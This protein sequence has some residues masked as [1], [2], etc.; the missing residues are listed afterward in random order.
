MIKPI[1]TVEQIPNGD[2]GIDAIVAKM[3]GLILKDRNEASVL[4]VA[5]KLKRPSD[6]KTIEATFNYVWKNY[7]YV[8]DPVDTEHLTAPRHIIG[9][10]TP[11]MD[12]DEMVILLNALL[13]A[14]KIPSRI[15]TIA[16][17]KKDFSHVISSAKF[18]NTWILLDPTKK[19]AGFGGTVKPISNKFWRMKKYG[20]PMGT[21]TT[22]DDC[23]GCRKNKKGL[24][25]EININIG[26]TNSKN[27]AGIPGKPQIVQLP[28]QTKTLIK[29][30]PVIYK[31]YVPMPT[32]SN[33][34][35][36]LVT[37]REYY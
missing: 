27:L 22:L 32:K 33:Y 15:I 16:W 12:C 21:L 36:G 29:K 26:N 10:R 34:A 17:R 4:K 25:N 18:D 19:R 2:R 28:G 7:K 8:P 5:R 6:Y 31:Q 3:W 11:H 20:D 1:K 23:G 24:N 37:Y 35:P 13:I 9:R 30:V 14:N